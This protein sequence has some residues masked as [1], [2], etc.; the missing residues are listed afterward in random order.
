MFSQQDHFFLIASVSAMVAIGFAPPASAQSQ[1]R[2]T[3]LQMA[4]EQNEQLASVPVSA[5]G[6][7]L[8]VKPIGDNVF[9]ISIRDDNNAIHPTAQRHFLLR[10]AG[11]VLAQN[12]CSKMMS[13][14]G[15]VALQNQGAGTEASVTATIVCKTPKSG[16]EGEAV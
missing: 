11:Y 6:P 14:V 16:D 10:N 8:R 7:H 9:S 3:Y 1:E 13:T 12:L 2:Q 5:I 4:Q 15:S